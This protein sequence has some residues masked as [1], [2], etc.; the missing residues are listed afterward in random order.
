MMRTLF[1]L[2]AFLAS[3][4]HAEEFLDPAVAFKPSARAIDGQ[5][6]EISYDIAKGYYLYRDKI[7]L[8]H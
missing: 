4:V 8:Q 2:L 1:L 6:I 3:L 5:T 7:P